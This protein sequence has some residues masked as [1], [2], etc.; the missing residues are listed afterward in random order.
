[1]VVIRE[2]PGLNAADPRGFEKDL[3]RRT[4]RV[5]DGTFN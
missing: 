2:L 4:G 1:M 3:L 5:L